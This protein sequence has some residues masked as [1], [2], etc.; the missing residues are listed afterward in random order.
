MEKKKKNKI[1]SENTMSFCESPLRQETQQDLAPIYLTHTP[2]TL[3][4]PKANHGSWD[5]ARWFCPWASAHAES[6]SLCLEC[7]PEAH[8][9]APA[10]PA[11]GFLPSRA[12]CHSANAQAQFH[13]VPGGAELSLFSVGEASSYFSDEAEMEKPDP[14]LLEKH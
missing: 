7:P 1:L 2:P 4:S 12:S 5:T 11:L 10:S 3:F 9:P 8:N 6:T 13:R 14:R